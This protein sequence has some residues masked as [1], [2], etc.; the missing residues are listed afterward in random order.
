MSEGKSR[1]VRCGVLRCH[2]GAGGLPVAQ[3]RRG[4]RLQGRRCGRDGRDADGNVDVLESG[5]ANEDTAAGA[6]M[7]VEVFASSSVCLLRRCSP[8][9]RSVPVSVRCWGICPKKHEEREGTRRRTRRVL[10]AELV[11]RRCRRSTT[12]T[13]D[14]FEAAL[15]GLRTSGST[16]RSARTTTTSCRRLSRSPKTKS[17]KPST[18]K[19]DQYKPRGKRSSGSEAPL[20]PQGG[21]GLPKLP[22]PGL[23]IKV[24]APRPPPLRPSIS[25]AASPHLRW[26]RR[27]ILHHA[28]GGREHPAV[29]AGAAEGAATR[30][31]HEHHP[32]QAAPSRPDI[33][34]AASPPLREGDEEALLLQVLRG[35]R[36]G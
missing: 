30:S 8:Q 17:T 27:S 13:L 14:F 20:S 7:R 3:G 26:E 15:G 32:S 1:F 23:I 6:W 29:R 22:S 12:S 2:V 10:P 35:R 18:P 28:V 25:S 21:A 34:P 11:G 33:R 5:A 36:L 16:R 31:E 9:P 24:P 4:R 19:P